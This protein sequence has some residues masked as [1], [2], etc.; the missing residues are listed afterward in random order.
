MTYNHIDKVVLIGTETSWA[1]GGT[2]NKGVGLILDD[3]QSSLS[4]EVIESFNVGDL[5]V[6]HVSAGVQEGKLS[7]SGEYQNAKLFEY[8]FGTVAHALST[9]DTTHTF[10]LSGA[11]SAT[12]KSDLNGTTDTSLAYTGMLVESLELSSS[13]NET[14]KV[15]AE[16][17]G[18]FP[19]VGT[20]GGAAVQ[21]A[22]PVSPHSFVSI[23]VA[24]S[25]ASE[26]QESSIN[27]TKEIRFSDS[28]GS[29][30]HEYGASTQIKVEFTAKVGFSANTYHNLAKA[31]ESSADFIFSIDNGTSLGS[32]KRALTVTVDSLTQEV[33]ELVTVGEL[34]YCDVKGTGI[35]SSCTSVDNILEANW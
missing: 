13:I 3:V 28:L 16:L 12:I 26:V 24:G 22:I 5:D 29:N 33:N 7:I 30:D 1:T 4:K 15:K 32:G 6:Q 20:S 9:S 25:A 2:A 10:T 27:F 19:T 23:T 11:T 8:L 35:I 14:V 34:V 31:S 21:S 18:K 17:R